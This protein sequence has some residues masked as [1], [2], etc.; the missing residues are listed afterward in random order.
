MPKTGNIFI[1]KLNAYANQERE[2][3]ERNVPHV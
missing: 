2:S 1:S 3:M